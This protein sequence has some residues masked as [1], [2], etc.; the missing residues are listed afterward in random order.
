MG[1]A[2]MGL[3]AALARLAPDVVVILGDRYEM[4]CA[5]A[6]ATVQGFP[7]A[8]LHGGELTEGAVDEAFRHAISKMARLHFTSAELYRRRVVQLGADPDTVFDVGA[9]GL[10]AIQDGEFMDAAE[11]GAS[12]GLDLPGSF[13]LVTLHPETISQRDHGADVDTVMN[14]LLG[15]PGLGLLVT[16]SNADAGGRQ[17][18]ARME[19]WRTARPDRVAFVANLGRKRYLS[20]VRACALVVGNSSSGIIEVPSLRVPTVDIGKRQK[21]RIRAASVLQAEFTE[22]SIE[23]AVRTALS[24]DFRAGLSEVVNPYGDGCT[25][26]RIVEIL[27]RRLD[28]D[29]L[30]ARAFFDLPWSPSDTP[31]P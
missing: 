9:L 16:G 22:A 23:Q 18:N 1:L 29:G 5:A 26:P 27:S 10:D 14:T 31:A 7:V 28:E 13:A 24:P 15:I 21:G 17:I 12:I 19:H 25:A 4:L 6:A 2:M 20:A 30:A 8:H 3:G 11:L